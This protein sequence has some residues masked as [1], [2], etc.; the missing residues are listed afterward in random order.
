[1]PKFNLRR[2]ITPSRIIFLLA[3]GI[4]ILPSLALAQ[5]LVPCGGPGNPCRVC[6]LYDLAKNV[7]NFLLWTVAAPLMVVALIA[8]G[9]V[10]LTS[11]GSEEKVALGRKILW[12]AVVGFLIAFAA[13]VI[14]NTILNTLVFKNPFNQKP[15]S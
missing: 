6:H 15:W 7:M 12:S 13:W 8:G 4:V 2:Y 10:W 3:A 14:V 1:M 11:A 9:I 5:G